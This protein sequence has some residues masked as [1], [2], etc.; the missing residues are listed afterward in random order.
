MEKITLEKM[1]TEKENMLDTL[2]ISDTD[3]QILNKSTI[4]SYT[5][6]INHFIL[7]LE[8]KNITEVTTSS[9]NKTLELYNNTLKTKKNNNNPTKTISNYTRNQ[10]LNK[11][12]YFLK[13]CQIPHTKPTQR[14]EYT[15]KHGKVIKYSEFLDLES[16]TN[17]N[18]RNKLLLDMMFY[19]G[20]RVSELVALTI[21]QIQQATKEN[22]TLYKVTI[23]GKGRKQRNI[24]LTEQLQT[25]LIKYIANRKE[26]SKYL[27]T[28]KFSKGG[29]IT[30]SAVR[31][32]LKKIC[33]NA[34]K[35]YK[36]KYPKNY[37]SNRV[38]PH[39]LRHSY[40]MHL[41][42]SNTPITVLKDMLGHS[43]IA[44]TNIYIE[45]NEKEIQNAY[46]NMYQSS[47]THYNNST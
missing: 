1:K 11:V 16:M 42:E 8:S 2:T 20:L 6:P 24:Y 32:N 40:A 17:G 28:S 7:Y 41:L 26:T 33:A 43:N 21:E 29:H 18:T 13:Y 35:K 34:D 27:F 14:N 37:F 23:K 4:R 19:T 45:S 36:N 3:N 38:T 25:E 10:Y 46:K 47:T 39:I 30:T 5:T 15:A 9:I 12:S 44:T 31:K 22:N